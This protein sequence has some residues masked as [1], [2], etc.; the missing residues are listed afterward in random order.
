MTNNTA[1][2]LILILF[3]PQVNFSQENDSNDEEEYD[4][5]FTAEG[6]TIYEE[7]P[8]AET[9][10]LS[11][12]NSSMSNRRNFIQN[13]LL[14]NA[15]FRRTANVRFRQTDVSE[16]GLS[17]LNGFGHLLSFGIIPATP[18]SEIDYARLPRGQY[19]SFE[20]VIIHSEFNNISLDVYNML[21]LE[22]M[23]QIEFANGFVITDTLNYYTEENIERFEY[24]IL[25]LPDS[26]DSIRQ[27]KERY[28]NIELPKIRRAIYQYNNPSENYL[29]A[30]ENL[31]GDFR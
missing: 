18:F 6:I 14:V 27:F 22:Y 23:L 5:L 13:D 10:I 3:M 31:R 16:K 11:A 21:K 26:P 8:P 15:G 19:Y 1:L 2:L 30:M 9:R 4:Y 12:L 17:I 7:R 28:L 24:L 20:S 29:R 25:S